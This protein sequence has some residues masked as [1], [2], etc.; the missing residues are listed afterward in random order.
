MKLMIIIYFEKHR[1]IRIH[2]CQ[3]RSVHWWPDQREA[4]T[5]NVNIY[6]ITKKSKEKNHVH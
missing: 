3:F 2:E 4:S 6:E 5:G 1:N